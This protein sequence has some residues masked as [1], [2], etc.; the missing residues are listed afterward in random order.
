MKVVLAPVLLLIFVASAVAKPSPFEVKDVPSL[1]PDD[2][3]LYLGPAGAMLE[4]D[5][6]GAPQSLTGANR[7]FPCRVKLQAAERRTSFAQVCD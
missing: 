6:F 1:P 7:I 4:S 2:N 5:Y 3:V